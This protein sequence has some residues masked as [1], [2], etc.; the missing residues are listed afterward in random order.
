MTRT[1]FTRRKNSDY[2]VSLP[3]NNRSK[4]LVYNLLTR[5]WLE[6]GIIKWISKWVSYL[7]VNYLRLIYG[8]WYTRPTTLC[9]SGQKHLQCH[10]TTSETS[11]SPVIN[12]PIWLFSPSLSVRSIFLEV[13]DSVTPPSRTHPT[14]VTDNWLPHG[15]SVSRCVK[16]GRPSDWEWCQDTLSMTI[17][18]V[19]HL[20]L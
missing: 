12:L 7:F 20:L 3:I 9:S 8:L 4:C 11:H 6:S 18:I 2:Y 14:L 13:H 5:N 16:C 19:K 1:G 17:I 10:F 15:L